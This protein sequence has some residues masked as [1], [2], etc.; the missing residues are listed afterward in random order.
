M[1]AFKP[2]ATEDIAGS[3]C[4]DITKHVSVWGDNWQQSDV[5][6]FG[7]LMEIDED[8]TY[9]HWFVVNIKGKESRKFQVLGQAI[10]YYN[11]PEG[12]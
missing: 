11:D 1:S 2:I 8:G 5:R 12:L 7:S 9:T 6:M 10:R 4:A 3:Y